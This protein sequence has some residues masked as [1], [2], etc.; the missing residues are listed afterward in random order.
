LSLICK[1]QKPL[2]GKLRRRGGKSDMGHSPVV[3]AT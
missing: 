3:K 1:K 2:D